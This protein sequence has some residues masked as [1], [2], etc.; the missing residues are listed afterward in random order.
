M[1]AGL[2]GAEGPGD[3]QRQFSR[4]AEAYRR[5]P[6]HADPVSLARFLELAQ[7]RPNHKVLDV[8]TGTGNVALAAA[9]D[10]AEVVGL[11]ITSSMLEQARMQA[12]EREIRNVRFVR[13]DAEML[14]YPAHSFDRVLVRSAPHHFLNLIKSLAEAYRVL[15]PGGVYAVSD[16]SPPPVVRDW[17][18]VVEL[19]RDPSHVR[20]RA[21]E[22]WRA[23][24]QGVGFTVEQAERIEQEK[25]VLQWFDLVRLPER[26]KRKLLDYYETAPQ[27]VRSQLLGQWREGRLYHRYW[28]AMIRARRPLQ[29]AARSGR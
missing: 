1:S 11:D 25:D 27:A 14:P 6:T 18:E 29:V 20:S 23:L 10:V 24:L 19:G 5:S 22:E 16:C 13:A 15:R 7:L 9:P 17:L 8:A 28:H 4:V 26:R 12:A 3:S 21:L 2:G